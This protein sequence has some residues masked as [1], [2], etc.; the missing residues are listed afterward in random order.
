MIK[1]LNT[2]SHH[3]LLEFFNTASSIFFIDI[4]NILRNTKLIPSQ[5][6]KTEIDNKL[7]PRSRCRNSFIKDLIIY[8]LTLIYIFILLVY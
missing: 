2:N 3:N 6:N 5:P 7:E 1:E 8:S 4:A